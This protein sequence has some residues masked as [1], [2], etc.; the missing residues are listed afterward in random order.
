MLKNPEPQALAGRETTQRAPQHSCVEE[1][2]D[3][4][5]NKHLERA[6]LPTQTGDLKKIKDHDSRYTAQETVKGDVA[7]E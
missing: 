5:H 2:F 7:L 4:L 6:S 3:W 1:R